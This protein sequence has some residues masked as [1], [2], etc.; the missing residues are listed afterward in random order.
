MLTRS[1]V[2]SSMSSSRRLGLGETRCASAISSSVECP[3]ADT[4]TTVS[5]PAARASATRFATARIRS[6]PSTEVPPYFWTRRDMGG[7]L[8][9]IAAAGA[10]WPRFHLSHL[11]RERLICSVPTPPLTVEAP[12]ED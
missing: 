10:S 1:P 4:T 5:W 12:G 3:I 6:G 8:Y 7:E 11:G 9:D 2:V